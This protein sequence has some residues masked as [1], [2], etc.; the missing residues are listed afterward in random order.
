[1]RAAAGVLFTDAC[2]R[3]LLVQPSYKRHWDL[4]GGEVELGESPRDAA[5]RE[6]K[7]ELGIVVVPGRLLVADMVVPTDGRETLAAFVF[8]GLLPV[9]EAGICADGTEILGWDW[10][11][12][13]EAEDRIRRA[14]APVLWSRLQ[15]AIG[16][17]D[18]H[19]TV[20]TEG[21]RL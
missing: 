10:C 3:V 9:G 6:V 16:A 11:R 14:G 17:R 15:L 1:V 8:E 2:G 21:G 5:A 20:Y 13:A 12:F 4:P 18:G 19:T 7:E